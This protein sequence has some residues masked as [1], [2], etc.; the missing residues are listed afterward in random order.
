MSEEARAEWDRVAP[1]LTRLDLL[2]EEDR[3]TLSAYC[4]TWSMWRQAIADIQENGLTCENKS[5]R[6]DGTESTWMTK[7]PAVA[8][9]QT[10]SQQLR[11]WAHEFGL[12]PSAESRIALMGVDDDDDDN[13]FA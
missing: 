3:A 8:I 10:A 4:E 1:G 9:A 2:K 11:Q 5:I 12:T 7:N 6:K 13:P